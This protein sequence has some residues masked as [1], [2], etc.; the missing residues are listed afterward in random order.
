MS[1][2]SQLIAAA[3][4]VRLMRLNV[5]YCRHQRLFQI[6]GIVGFVDGTEVSIV[7]PPQNMNPQGFWTRKHQY[8]INCQMV[9]NAG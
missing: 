5:Q 9:S 7:T 4:T 2:K 1:G 8:A 3:A 6:P